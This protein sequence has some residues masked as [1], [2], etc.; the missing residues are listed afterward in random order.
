MAF[1][2][3]TA[4][5]NIGGTIIDRLL[6]DKAANDAAKAQLAQAALQGQF[7]E[8]MGQLEIN[9]VEAASNSVFVAGWRPAVGWVCAASVAYSYI[10]QPLLQFSLVAFHVNFDLTKLPQLNMVELLGLLTGMLGFGL[11]RSYDK[12]QGTDNGH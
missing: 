5:L 10:M 8:I 9:K 6:P 11:A 12:A 1:D 2:P 7:N 4:V 3:L